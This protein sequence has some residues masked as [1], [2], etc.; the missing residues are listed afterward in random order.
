MS[1]QL[2]AVAAIIE[3][4]ERYAAAADRADGNSVAALFAPDGRMVI[5]APALAEPETLSG[6]EAIARRIDALRRFEFASH[7]LGEHTLSVEGARASGTR[8]C[9]AHH[10]GGAAGLGIDRVVAL[11]YVDTYASSGGGAWCFVERIVRMH[12]EVFQTVNS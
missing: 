4:S 11:T 8:E 1:D 3:L 9:E 2:D 6:R 5:E 7:R 10:V 12:A